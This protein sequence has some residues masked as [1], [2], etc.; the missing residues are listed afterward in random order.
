MIVD[1][2]ESIR[3]LLAGQ[4]TDTPGCPIYS[5]DQITFEQPNEAAS[6]RD[7]EARVN[8]Y[9]CS[10]TENVEFRD[11]SYL[12]VR[13][14][15][16]TDAGL[17]RGPVR[18]ALQYMVT[19]HAGG[20][21]MLEHR[22]LSDVVGVLFK[23]SAI[24]DMYLRGLLAGMGSNAILM[25]AG[26]EADDE[27]VNALTIWQT[28]SAKP[29][30]SL[31]LM[32]T[33]P[34]NPFETRWTKVVRQAILGVGVGASLNNPE[35]AIKTISFDLCVVGIVL[36]RETEKPVVEA[37]VSVVVDNKSTITDDQGIFKL[38]NLRAGSVTLL[39]EAAGYQSTE[40]EARV[41]TG[42]HKEAIEPITVA[43]RAIKM[44]NFDLS[45]ALA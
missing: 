23:Y 19:A 27:I 7:G 39:V 38:I 14:N 25:R 8:L 31:S 12:R 5:V 9:L 40:L 6:L 3:S 42:D 4:L 32:V 43:L 33:A 21:P 34:Y 41:F 1:V 16:G 36:D 17:Q 20:N 29:Q 22:L 10:L 30:P 28:F 44:R 11:E 24:P 45:D 26:Q 15:I 35:G 18:I 2:D 13:K 37:K